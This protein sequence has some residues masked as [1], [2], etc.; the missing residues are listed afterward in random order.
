MRP[1]R[2][3]DHGDAIAEIDRLLDI[4]GDEYKARSGRVTKPVQLVLQLRLGHGIECGKRF[5]H[6]QNGGAQSQRA[7]DLHALLHAAG[8]LPR[9]VVAVPVQADEPQ[10]LVHPLVDFAPRQ[11]AF[12]SEGDVAGHR[13]PLQQSVRIVLKDDDDVR[14][15]AVDQPPVYIYRAARAGCQSAEH[16]QQRRLAG[17][18]WPDNGQELAAAQLQR[19]IRKDS[20]HPILVRQFNRHIPARENEIRRCSRRT[21]GTRCIH[22]AVT[23]ILAL[24]IGTDNCPRSFSTS[25]QTPSSSGLIVNR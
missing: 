9:I 22:G 3:G 14:W 25:I 4:V 11:L 18:G 5:V 15:R 17:A 20:T 8:K 6:E 12:Q 24:S 10:R 21:T 19:N 13:P 7:R 16:A 2:A 1:G 23:T